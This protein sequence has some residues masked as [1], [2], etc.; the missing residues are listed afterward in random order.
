MSSKKITPRVAAA[1][2]LQRQL[3]FD[4]SNKKAL[5]LENLREMLGLKITQSTA[6]KIKKQIEG[7]T[8]KLRKR[9]DNVIAKYN[10]PKENKP[11]P[12]VFKEKLE[13]RKTKIKA[14][15]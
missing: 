3:D 12:A 6:D 11:M 10:E 14:K 2:V 4:A 13:K 7:F 1:M 8:N 5:E 15:A 9:I